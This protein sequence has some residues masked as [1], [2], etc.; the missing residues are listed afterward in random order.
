[1]D[2][3]RP[4]RP[5]ARV[6]LVVAA[7]IGALL[8]GVAATVSA[9]QLPPCRVGDVYTRHRTYGDWQ[10][11]LLDLTYRLG[12]TYA[13]K[14]LRS[15]STA[16]LNGG[17]LVRGFVVADLKA[18]ASAARA[19]GA[20]FAVQSAYRS[21]STQKATFDYWVRVS[22]Y[23]QAIISSARAGHSEHQL[24]TTVDLRSHGGS[25]PWDYR[26]WGTTKAGAWLK[27]NAWKYGFIMAYPKGKTS[28]TC[29][30]YEPWH[31][32]YVGRFLASKI[33][34]SGLTL[35]EYLWRTQGQPVPT[36]T[37]QPTPTPTPSPTSSPTPTAPPTPSASPSPTAT[38]Q[39]T[40]TPTPPPSPTP[41]P[42][43][44]PSPTPQ[45]SPTPMPTASPSPTPPP[46]PTPTAPDGAGASGAALAGGG[47]DGSGSEPPVSAE[48]SRGG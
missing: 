24:G 27:T 13:P 2:R 38:A 28:V 20:R 35:R 23:R 43:A 33:R 30:T 9:S 10:R 45:P 31:Y 6:R 5:D 16:G 42:T 4:R 41:T 26:D 32:R 37:P 36:P 1:M 21:Y 15:T 14:D 18:M 29:Y 7:L 44:S 47:S 22:G 11:S 40:S 19:A 17:Y 34:S 3:P 25:A 46:S 12:S 39:P 48:Q 8:V